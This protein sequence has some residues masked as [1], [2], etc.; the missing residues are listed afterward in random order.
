M[1]RKGLQGILSGMANPYAY[2][3]PNAQPNPY[4]GGAP[5]K[6]PM[7]ATIMIGSVLVGSLALLIGFLVS[8]MTASALGGFNPASFAI[9]VAI[10][11]G[12]A[13]ANFLVKR[14]KQARLVVAIL[15]GFLLI[16]SLI[17]FLAHIALAISGTDINSMPL[18][19]GTQ[20]WLVLA[21][22]LNLI[23]AACVII[24]YAT[25]WMKPTSQ[26][27]KQGSNA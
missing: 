1:Y 15:G 6:R 8:F 12:L 3:D 19:S 13:M 4:V 24:Y 11:V 25:A 17:N 22:L 18:Q 16:V 9:V 10:V 23:T 27:Y 26:W 2:P 14:N 21:A 20:L 7:T 5:M